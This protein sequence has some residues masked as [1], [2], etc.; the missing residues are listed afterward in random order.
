MEAYETGEILGQGTYGVVYKGKCKTTGVEVAIKRTLYNEFL[1]L[2]SI[3]LPPLVLTK[4]FLVILSA[5]FPS[6]KTSTIL[7]LSSFILIFLSHIF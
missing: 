4:V 7:T 6:L 1:S 2:S 3:L 5:K